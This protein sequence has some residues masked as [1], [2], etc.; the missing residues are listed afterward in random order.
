MKVLNRISVYIHL[1]DRIATI[2]QTDFLLFKTV[3]FEHFLFDQT[4]GDQKISTCVEILRKF[5]SDRFLPI[6]FTLTKREITIRQ[7]C[8]I[9]NNEF[10]KINNKVSRGFDAKNIE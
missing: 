8:H 9:R 6:L 3:F 10:L 5:P 4:K 7:T 2:L 1:L